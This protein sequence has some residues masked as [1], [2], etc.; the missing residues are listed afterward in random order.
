MCSK[1]SQLQL[2]LCSVPPQAVGADFRISP[3]SSLINPGSWAERVSTTE[4]I[5]IESLKD[6][7][8]HSTQPRIKSEQSF[9]GGEGVDDVLHAGVRDGCSLWSRKSSGRQLSAG[10]GP[11]SGSRGAGAEWV[12]ITE[13]PPST[14]SQFTFLLQPGPNLILSICE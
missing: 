9:L 14:L 11:A 13:L 4:I 2:S 7:C 10:T 6:L 12:C 3:Q 5:R 8:A 1:P